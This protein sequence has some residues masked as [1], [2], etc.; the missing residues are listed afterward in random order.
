MSTNINIIIPKPTGQESMFRNYMEYVNQYIPLDYF[1]K[2]FLS[3]FYFSQSIEDRELLFSLIIEAMIHRGRR[4]KW[5]SN[6]GTPIEVNDL[7]DRIFWNVPNHDIWMK[8]CD[9]IL[10]I[11]DS[12]EQFYTSNRFIHEHLSSLGNM[13]SHFSIISEIGDDGIKLHM[14]E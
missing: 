4:M 8:I 3:G 12:F 14:V 9:T 2:I 5:N 10:Q 1:T 6:E 11:F 13:Y 7:M